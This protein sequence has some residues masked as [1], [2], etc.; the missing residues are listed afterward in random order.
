MQSYMF[1]LIFANMF[2]HFK[3]NIYKM[4][5]INHNATQMK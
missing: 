1:I 2:D 4:I 5:N 3:G